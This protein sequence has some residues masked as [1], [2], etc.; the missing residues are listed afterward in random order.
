MQIYLIPITYIKEYS[1]I[2]DNVDEKII[3]TSILDAQEQLLEPI[4]GTSL[5]DK[6]ID[7]TAAKTLVSDYQNLIVEKIWPYMLHAVAYKVALNLIYRI[8]NTSVVKNSNEVSTAISLQE[9]NVMRQERENAMRH[10]EDKLRLYLKNNT[11]KF[12]EYVDYDVEGLPANSVTQPR[13]FYVDDDSLP[14]TF[15]ESY[16]NNR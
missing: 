1:I 13:N 7:D 8:S 16:I 14:M 12:P 4:L 10:A 3:K 6:L 5:Y 2:D 11:T 9:L 15:T